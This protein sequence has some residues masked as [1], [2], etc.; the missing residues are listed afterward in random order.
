M[1][2]TLDGTTCGICMQIVWRETTAQHF[3]GPRGGNFVAAGKC[4]GCAP[5]L[6]TRAPHLESPSLGD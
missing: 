2:D 3:P 6:R 1:G 4:K 5:A